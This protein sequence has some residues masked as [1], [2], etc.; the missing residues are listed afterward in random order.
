MRVTRPVSSI[1]YNTEQFLIKKL[2]HLLKLCYLSYWE[3]IPHKADVDT[4]KPHIH[5]YCV[6]SKTLDLKTFQDEFNE[7]DPL[8]PEHDLKC[9]PFRV[10]N[11]YGDW[12]WYGLH[13]KDYLKAKMMSRNCYYS[14]SDIRSSDIDFHEV[15]VS[16]NPLINFANLSDIGLR[17]WVFECVST[18][19]SLQYCLT[20]AKVPLGK[21]QSV[22]AFYNALS[23]YY[24]PKTQMNPIPTREQA[25]GIKKNITLQKFRSIANGTA[26]PI[27]ENIDL[28][29]VTD[30][31]FD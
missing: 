16:E 23:T 13:D 11:S 2:N 14:D 5:L 27:V 7:F 29:S 24:A 22:I 8:N 30:D 1:S 18:G 28:F 26:K 21:V 3:F 20:G 19:S 6:P 10:S 4:K 31:L 15:L 25:K 12:Y 17:E 9:M